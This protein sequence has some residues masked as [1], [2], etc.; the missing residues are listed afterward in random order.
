M[1]RKNFCKKL[2][3]ARIQANLKQ[4]TAAKALRIPTSAVSAFE[5]GS[6]KLDVLELQ[7]LAKLYSKKMQWFFESEDED[8]NESCYNEETLLLEAYEFA[9]KAPPQLQKAV[10]CAIMGFLKESEPIK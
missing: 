10:S 8:S 2:K 7:V 1:N 9:K 4:E 5:A 3:L 6:R